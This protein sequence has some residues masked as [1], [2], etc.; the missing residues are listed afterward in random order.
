MGLHKVKSIKRVLENIK[1]ISKFLENA[2]T[3][4]KKAKNV[5]KESK[6]FVAGKMNVLQSRKC[7]SENKKKWKNR[8][9]ISKTKLLCCQNSLFYIPLH[10]IFILNEFLRDSTQTNTSK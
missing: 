3:Y 9:R 7:T 4:M 1:R 8:R 2:D 10:N 6:T 5:R